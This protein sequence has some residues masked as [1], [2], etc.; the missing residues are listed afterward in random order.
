MIMTLAQP[1]I[2]FTDTETYSKNILGPVSFELSNLRV[3]GSN[4][5]P[6]DPTQSPYIV[7]SD[8]T[9]TLEVDVEFNKSPLSELLM[10]LGT[11]INIDFAFEGI[12]RHAEDANVIAKETTRK[13]QFQYTLTYR[14][15][16]KVAGLSDGLYAIAAVAKIGPVNNPCSQ[17]ILGYGYI[18][19][20][21]FQVY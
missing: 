20:V 21:L 3:Q 4:T 8:E 12:G 9:F 6:A 5:A 7:A 11:E 16:P 13:G 10:C 17:H 1:R 15:V 14:G 19:R 2:Q 18:A